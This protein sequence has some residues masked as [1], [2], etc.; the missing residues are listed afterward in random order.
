M[1]NINAILL[2]YHHPI[3]TD[4]PTI[5]E[6]VNAFSHLSRFKTWKINS[7]LGFPTALK[8]FN[9]NIIVL[10]Y[11]LF[12]HPISLGKHFQSYLGSVKNSY[13][14]AFFQDEHEYWP[15]RVAFINEFDLNCIYSLFEPRYFDA[16][17][18][19]YTKVPKVLYNLT[20][21]VS[22]QMIDFANQCLKPY[23]DRKIDVGYR[24][25]RLPYYLGRGA[26]EKS[27]IAEEFKRRVQ[28][29]DLKIDIETDEADR[30]YGEAWY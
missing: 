10:H 30:I 20:G 24:A 3:K 27:F 17:Y 14:I 2:L 5:K 16:S 7:A 1:Q 28:N 13:K 29:T 4:A 25:R 6:H 18:G 19:K 26:Q 15:E 9:F 11:S 21:Y 12:G 8:S 23:D 22:D